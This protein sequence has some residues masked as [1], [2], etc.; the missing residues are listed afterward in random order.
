MPTIKD[1]ARKAGVSVSTA[2]YALNNVPLV[3]PETRKRVMEVAEAINYHPNA[4]ARNLKTKKTNNIGVFVY[5]FSGPVF[6]EIL[7][8]INK[9]VHARNMNI[10]VSSGQS[11][12]MM[13][14][15]KQV[16]GA[17][18]FD[19]GFDKKVIVQYA[20]N[21]PVVV[22]DTFLKG[23]NIYPSVMDNDLLVHQLIRQMINQG[24]Q[25]F[26]YVSGPKDAFNNKER[27]KGYLQ[28]LQEA[29]L[30]SQHYYQGDFT[31]PSG[32]QAG[33]TIVAMK[34]RPDFVFCA[35]DEMALG[36]MEA[37][38]EAGVG[39]PEAIGVAGFDG[40]YLNNPYIKPSLTTVSIDHY[41]WGQTAA[42]FLIDAL[43]QS[44]EVKGVLKPIGKIIIKESTQR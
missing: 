17:I 18:I 3:N 42:T 38:R 41:A 22:L 16:D 23:K 12:S 39:V 11:S 25:R 20:K 2:S 24:Y 21:S 19:S 40:S 13:L 32:Y 27:Y 10:L 4:S 15:E 34:T 8:G 33:K 29:G 14:R 43:Q 9:V 36:V 30:K 1:V 28:A 26:V 35:N 44:G 7:E 5:G 31:T 37:L 6:S